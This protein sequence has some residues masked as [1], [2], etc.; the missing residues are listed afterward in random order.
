MLCRVGGARGGGRG[1]VHDGADG[2]DGACLGRGV[3]SGVTV[4]VC[5]VVVVVGGGG[6]GIRSRRGCA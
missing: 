6:I 1:P 2:R 5:V 4:A 3:G